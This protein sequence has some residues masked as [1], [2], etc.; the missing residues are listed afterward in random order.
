MTDAPSP[1]PPPTDVLIVGGGLAGPTLAL[2]LAR[3]GLSSVLIDARPE[4]ISDRYDG[5]SY[6]LAVASRRLL[7]R[8]GVWAHVANQAQPI[9]AIKVADPSYEVSSLSGGNQQKVVIGKALMT[10]PKVLLMDE[11]SR[12]I[13][14]GA[15]ADVFKTMRKLAADGLGILFA[16]SDLEEVMALSDRIA[17]MSNGKLIKIFDRKDATEEAVIAASAQGHGLSHSNARH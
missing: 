8:V 9:L 1:P 10:N 16:T 3:E 14:V 17:V 2:A 15:K 5:R 4:A 6:A 13:D 7:A 12:G 11:P